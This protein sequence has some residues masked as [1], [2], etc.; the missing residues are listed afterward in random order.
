MRVSNLKASLA[1]ILF[2][3]VVLSTGASAQVT[4][5]QVK[6]KANSA[7]DYHVIYKYKG[8]RGQY[9]FDYAYT[10][11]K[12]RT[13]IL[14]SKTA[15]SRVGTVVVYDKGW[16]K[17]RIRAKLGGGLIVRKTTHKDVKDTPFYRSIFGMVFDQTGECGKPKAK[18][19]G[20]KTIF[21]FKCPGGSYKVWAD[22]KAQIV[23]TE[24]IADRKK[25]TRRFVGHQWNSKPKTDF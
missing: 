17:S 7:K 3:M 14:R 22:S 23:K 1:L 24:R 12:V 6:K 5:D 18:K 19:S 9:D 15:K 8:P 2:G 10:K 20:S 4:W 21:T 11:Q 16:D 25:E 13:E